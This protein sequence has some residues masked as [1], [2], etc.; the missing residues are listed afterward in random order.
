MS[1]PTKELKFIHITK[2]AGTSIETV[3][4]EKNK[5]WGINHSEYGFWHA[6]FP[7]KPTALKEKYDWFMVVRNPYKRI[8]SEYH[9]LAGVFE[10]RHN[11][12]EFNLFIKKWINNASNDKETHPTYGRKGGDHF[13]EQYKYL[14]SNINIHI[15][16]F[17]N[18]EEEFNSLMTKYSYNIILNKKIQVSKKIF[19]IKDFSSETLQ[20]IQ[21]VY[22][23]DF[24][25]FGY[26]MDIED[27]IPLTQ[28][29]IASKEL[30]FINITETEGTSIEMVGHKHNIKWGKYHEEY[31]YHHSIFS[32]KPAQLKNKHNWFMVVRDPYT[33][34][35]SEY[36]Y[37]CKIIPGIINYSVEEFNKFIV[38][39]MKAAARGDKEN[40]SV[41]R[42]HFTEQYKY[43]DP[44]IKIH[45]LKFENIEEEFNTLM[46][47][48]SYNF[49]LV[50]HLNNSEKK[51]TVD[52][53]T[54][55][56][57]SIIN[58]I[59]KKDFDLF[60]YKQIKTE[61]STKIEI[62]IQKS[63]K[64]KLKYIPITRIANKYIYDIATTLNLKWGEHHNE[65]GSPFE[66][67]INKEQNLKNN[68]RILSEYNFLKKS[69][70]INKKH[71]VEEFNS[72]IGKWIN[73]IENGIE[74][75]P[76]FGKILGDHF[77]EQ[78]KYYDTQI[79]PHIIKYENIQEEMKS[80]LQEYNFNI[81]LQRFN[82][83]N[84][85]LFGFDDISTENLNL[86]NR[87]YKKDFELFEYTIQEVDKT[88]QKQLKF[89][90]I[91]RNGG[92]SIEQCGLDKNKFWGR[93]DI[94]YGL[95]DEPF[96]QKY[97]AL[98]R[99]YVWFTV[100]RNPYTRVISEYNYLKHILR[101]RGT[102]SINMF[103]SYIEKWLR[104]IKKSEKVN[105]WHLFPQYIYIDSN[106]DI[107]I[108]KFENLTNTFNELM[109]KFNYD[110]KLNRNVSSSNSQF[111]VKDL[112]LTNIEL[113]KEIYKKDFEL[114]G[115]SV[116][117]SI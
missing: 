19:G 117:Y 100:V 16:K 12:E 2:T 88:L 47:Q 55:E 60:G 4:L 68:S 69:I 65:Y 31:G 24:E 110:I 86:I 57:I 93:Y 105:G 41:G 56:T 113:I 34:V 78:Y 111:T 108:I 91:T 92:T 36:H 37:L 87:V 45:V 67:F 72:I 64:N 101:I 97:C 82:I 71:T 59:Y 30:K 102:E 9:F 107:N 75:H 89:I 43:L 25:L 42:D 11:K 52:D 23:K 39:W 3:G 5:R 32:K 81:N 35:L 66:T 48:Y 114:F 17:E 26:S 28:N 54:D 58:N 40:A 106:Y 80:L 96:I 20:L 103:N 74:N 77:T 99:N 10:N 18:I 70:Y 7:N 62:P 83:E 85:Y 109:N 8:L 50:K 21:R 116:D 104:I 84:D 73:N 94:A 38:N 63:C 112:S 29:I 22:K 79:K 115:Y 49:T 90:H 51:Y 33:R 95:F 14:D 76:K 13:T 44:S 15:L 6:T 46:K 98:K 27:K 53:L 61:D 1:V